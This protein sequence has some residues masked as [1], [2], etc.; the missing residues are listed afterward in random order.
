[1]KLIENL[2]AIKAEKFIITDAENTWANWHKWNS[3]RH[4][5]WVVIFRKVYVEGKRG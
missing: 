2:I 3:I 1:M 4:Q 5:V